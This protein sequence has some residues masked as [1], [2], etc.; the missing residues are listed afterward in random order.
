MWMKTKS[1]CWIWF[2]RSLLYFIFCM[3][4]DIWMETN[5]PRKAFDSPTKP[6]FGD[7]F[8]FSA[9]CYLMQNV[10]CFVLQPAHLLA[11]REDKAFGIRLKRFVFCTFQLPLT[12]RRSPSPAQCANPAMERRGAAVEMGTKMR[13][14]D[15]KWKDGTSRYATFTTFLKHS[16]SMPRSLTW[17]VAQMCV[18]MFKTLKWWPPDFPEFPSCFQKRAMAQK[19]KV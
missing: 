19:L 9:C 15:I 18:P 16:Q 5:K 7:F 11:Q 10:T 2:S 3:Y 13:P 1:V 4:I 12:W 6:D 8:F 14:V 17:N